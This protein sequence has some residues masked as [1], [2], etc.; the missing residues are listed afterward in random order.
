MTREWNAPGRR[1][2]I[3]GGVAVVFLCGVLVGMVG[4]DIYR[5]QQQQQ[6]WQQGLAALKPR[7]MRNLTDELNLSAEQQHAVQTIVSQAERELLGLRIAQQPQVDDIMERTTNR[8]KTKLT[9]EQHRKL[10]ELY[11]KLQSRWGAD[12]EYL[13]TL[14][15]GDPP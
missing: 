10:E 13:Q 9:P 11:R 2:R 3:W 5:D 14:P 4:T 7:V 12:R 6:R 8:L 15:V 1:G